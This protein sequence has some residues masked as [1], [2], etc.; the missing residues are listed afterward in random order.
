MRRWIA[1]LLV[2]TSLLALSACKKEQPKEHE[3]GNTPTETFQFKDL[4]DH[5]TPEQALLDGCMVLQ[6]DEGE[7]T[8]RVRGYDYWE[9]FLK[10]CREGQ[11]ISLRV[12]YFTSS[13]YWFSDIYYKNINGEDMFLV[14]T[15]DS[16]SENQIG[17][18][19][20]LTQING[21]DPDTKENVNFFV[22]TDDAE[23]GAEDV[24]SIQRI[25]D[26]E[27]ER[28]ISFKILDFTTYF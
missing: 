10:T 22:L 27:A 20:Y 9:T 3:L 18:F 12:L 24:F 1:F 26:I 19:K 15:R 28:S 13:T 25:C 16:Y 21:K 23:L 6:W 17:P 2:L 7:T 4:E 8:P 11:K 14:Y 5:Y